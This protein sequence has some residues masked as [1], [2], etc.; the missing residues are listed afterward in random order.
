M[1]E[2]QK[3]REREKERE[4]ERE[5]KKERERD[6]KKKRDRKRERGKNNYLYHFMLLQLSNETLKTEKK[7]LDRTFLNYYLI[8]N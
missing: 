4:R 2:R 1:S 7:N 3:N 5:R 6:R 8:L